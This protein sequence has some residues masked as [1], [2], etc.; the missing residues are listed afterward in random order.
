MTLKKLSVLQKLEPLLKLDNVFDAVV[1]GSFARGSLKPR[2]ID[3]AIIFDPPVSMDIK[4]DT[5]QKAREMLDH[6]FEITPVNLQEIFSRNFKA[7]TGIISEGISIRSKKRLSEVMGFKPMALF[8]YSLVNLSNSKKTQ[9]K[10]ALSG[11]NG[12]GLL[13]ERGGRFLGKGCLIV[14][15]EAMDE[16]KL[17]FNSYNVK[18]EVKK[19]LSE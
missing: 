10:Y 12:K 9:L 3:V 15:I 16:F 8:T 11:R 18:Y 2:D 13:E 4:L 5:A 14:P 19:I 7:R 17:L 6:F 1:F